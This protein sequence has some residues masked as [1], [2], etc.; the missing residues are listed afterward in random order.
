MGSGEAE[1]IGKIF[2]FIFSVSYR[3][4]YVHLL[5]IF[6]IDEEFMPLTTSY[7]LVTSGVESN[8]GVIMSVGLAPSV[9]KD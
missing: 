3:N 8:H 1:L 7:R 2:V 5:Q 9:I 6:R 4:I